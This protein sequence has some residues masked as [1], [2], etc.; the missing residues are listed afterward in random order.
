M[1][2]IL[3]FNAFVT[4]F[5]TFFIFVLGW[6]RSCEN[7][8]FEYEGY[9]FEDE[10]NYGKDEYNFYVLKIKDMIRNFLV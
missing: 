6:W 2:N 4:Q 7:Y 1:S 5:L 10:K 9:V 3:I 8:G